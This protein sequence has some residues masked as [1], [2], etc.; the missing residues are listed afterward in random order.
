MKFSFSTFLVV[1]LAS[2]EAVVASTWFGKTGKASILQASLWSEA[3]AIS[4]YNKWHET[5]LERWLS[6]HDVPYPT[7][8]DRKDLEIL[9]KDNWQAM[10]VEPVSG[11]GEKASGQ[12][13][14]V[15]DWIFD[16]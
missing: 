4:A 8:A 7:P 11:A 3:N 5:E 2:T 6:D 9:V 12:F 16:R 14:S 10:V 15:K 1:A 13:G